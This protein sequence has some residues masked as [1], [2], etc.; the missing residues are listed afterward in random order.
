MLVLPAVD[1]DQFATDDCRE[2]VRL[3][4]WLCAVSKRET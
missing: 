2:A 3:T 4:L 1:N